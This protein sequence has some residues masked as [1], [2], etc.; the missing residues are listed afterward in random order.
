MQNRNWPSRDR[1]AWWLV[2]AALFVAAAFTAY[3]LVGTFA[4]GLFL[5]Y[6]TRPVYR[7]L[8]TVVPSDGLAAS[9]TLL[10]TALPG[11]VLIFYLGLQGL[12]E[13]TPHLGAIQ[14]L[15][16]PYV[17]IQGLTQEPVNTILEFVRNPRSGE[18]GRVIDTVSQYVGFVTT[19]LQTL[20]IAILFALY[21]LRDG[22]RIADWFTEN[23]GGDG[24]PAHAYATAVDS[25]LETIYFGNVLLVLVVALLS[26]VVFHGY[27]VLAPPAVDIPSPTA[28]ALL[29]G[30]ATLIPII[31]GKVVYVPLVA[32]LASVA[33]R[34]EP[35]MLFPLGLLVVSFLLLDFIP[36]TFLLPALAGRH[37]HIG[38]IM[39]A[40]ILGILIFGWYGLF[41]GPLLVVLGIQAVRIVVPELLAG[42]PVS[43]K[44]GSAEDLGS[45]P[46][47]KSETPEPEET[48][49]EDA[50]IEEAGDGDPTAGG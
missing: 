17:N 19:L 2:V 45:D 1:L 44:V 14:G 34:S 16:E 7:R 37:T 39:F 50:S 4:L 41:L 27:N 18:I 31:V 25:D 24:T 12:N 3:S 6:G 21:L 10:L 42:V 32:Y 46:E 8:R 36:M 29:M 20:F 35:S 33:S 11:L 26:T 48:P 5:Y 22:D 15:L 28:V 47:E 43:P 49:G 13:V 40:Y 23:V 38:V 30:F 9:L